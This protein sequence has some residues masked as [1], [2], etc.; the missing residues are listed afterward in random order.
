MRK[1]RGVP[2]PVVI[3]LLV[4]VG[5]GV[6]F[7]ST[8]LHSPAGP[9]VSTDK[10][11]VATTTDVKVVSNKPLSERVSV[12]SP[13]PGGTVGKTFTITGKAPGNWFFEA[14]FPVQVRSSEGDVLGRAVAHTQS[15]WMTESLVSFTADV[16]ISDPKY[17]GSARLILMRD[18]PSGLPEN[19]DAIE[20]PIMIR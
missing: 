4:V 1:K 18:N 8:M 6:W 5:A 15:D 14:S 16:T 11:A 2:L 3:V 20:I 19:D 12:S 9:A 7:V 10:K 13:G 17:T